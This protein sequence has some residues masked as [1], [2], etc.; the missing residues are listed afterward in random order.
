ML[1]Y[2]ILTK[3]VLKILVPPLSF[4][5]LLS[6][7]KNF[8]FVYRLH[9]TYTIWFWLSPALLSWSVKD[10]LSAFFSVLFLLDICRIATF[11]HSYALKRELLGSIILCWSTLFLPPS[12]SLINND[13][14]CDLGKSWTRLISFYWLIVLHVIQLDCKLLENRNLVLDPY[15]TSHS[16]EQSLN[17]P[18]LLLTDSSLSILGNQS[19]R[20]YLKCLDNWFLSLYSYCC[21]QVLS[22]LGLD[23]QSKHIVAALV[24]LSLYSC[25][26]KLPLG[27]E[28]IHSFPLSQGK[29]SKYFNLKTLHSW[30]YLLIFH[31]SPVQL[32]SPV[33]CL[34]D[35]L[36]LHTW[37]RFTLFRGTLLHTL[38]SSLYLQKSIHTL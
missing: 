7:F 21:C 6:Y 1:F 17:A 31:Y 36:S 26:T 4:K 11:G 33:L 9:E 16:A 13:Q 34:Y 25:L 12:T 3:K 8:S 28:R 29:S 38:L 22:S 37:L 19:A 30:I 24:S 32:G 15:K 14:L 2:L 10:K 35:T 18:K 5:K 20:I 23:Y 27:S